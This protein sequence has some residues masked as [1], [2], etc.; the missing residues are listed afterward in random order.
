MNQKIK[1]LLF[2]IV[3]GGGL[4]MTGGTLSTFL[5]YLQLTI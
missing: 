2:S 3:I 1:M 5:P 4:I